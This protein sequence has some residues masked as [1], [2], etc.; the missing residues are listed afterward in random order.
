[1][2]HQSPFCRPLIFDGKKAS[3]A[4]PV[5]P[6]APSPSA[7]IPSSY[8]EKTP[9]IWLRYSLVL[10][11]VW[12][13]VV[14]L[15]ELQGQSADILTAAGIQS[16]AMRHWLIGAGAIFDLAIGLWLFFK[17][18]RLV[19][20]LAFIGMCAMTLVASILL[21]SLWLHP[22]GP[23]SKNLPIA[24]GLWVLYLAQSKRLPS[25]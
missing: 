22:L 25:V 16:E 6:H 5:V 7:L 18:G 24:A 19:Y 14:S 1:M 8:R 12:T 4:M 13:G 11:W 15:L 17:P 3:Q 10:V 21:P 20:A 23:L 9:F 2:P